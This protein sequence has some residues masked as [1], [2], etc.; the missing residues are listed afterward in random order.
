MVAVALYA[1]TEIPTRAAP[2]SSCPVTS[3][4]SHGAPGHGH[5]T[6]YCL[7][8]NAVRRAFG[9]KQG[10]WF[11]AA[12]V[13]G[14]LLRVAWA[15]FA[16]QPPVRLTDP[17][18][19]Q[20]IAQGF[21]RGDLPAIGNR[22][23]AFWPPGYP[24]AITPLAWL[25]DKTGL[26]LSLAAS[27]LNAVAGTATIALVAWL[28]QRWMGVRARNPAAWLMALGP[29]PIFMTATSLSETWFTAVLLGAVVL[30]T[31]AADRH[32]SL[33]RH[34]PIGMLV[35]YL[36]LVR[37]PGL[38][39]LFAVPLV[40]KAVGGRW[41]PAL[42]PALATV[43]GMVL[44]LAPWAVRNGVQVGV[45]SPTS[46]N[47]AAFV[48]LGNGEGADGRQH[49]TLDENI[50]CYRGSA[51]DNP[52]L[53]EPGEVSP[54]FVFTHPDEPAWYQATL[55]GTAG[56]VVHH[57]LEQPHLMFVKVFDTF[58]SDSESLTDG[59]GFGRNHKLPPRGRE[60]LI[61]AADVWLWGVLGLAALG[62]AFL[63]RARAALP[64]WGL[65]ALQLVLI[66]P[67]V[68]IQRYHHPIM[69]LLAVF[70]AGVIAALR[71]EPASDGAGATEVAGDDR[72]DPVASGVVR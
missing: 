39:A 66:V 55:R 22:P 65:A 69:V 40:I 10:R 15:C 11:L 9:G 56:Y 8:V 63:R 13:V 51:F 36:A 37:T 47:N 43:V 62:L 72:D 25:A 24:M 48:C 42:R 31:L 60:V 18:H 1:N 58:K 23:S 70:A 4:F 12:L 32:W 20:Q 67:G 7:A 35:G 26:D 30:A 41:R 19:Y 38:L 61:R 34:V 28:A 44:V 16:T 64:L 57:P 52:A 59:E 2:P 21:A 46:T 3:A 50:R 17:W 5:A 27:L 14:F 45:W 53:Y 71:D 6:R 33:A 29:G 49:L 68:G 54:G